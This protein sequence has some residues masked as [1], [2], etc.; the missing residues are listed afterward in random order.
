MTVGEILRL[1]YS[2]HGKVV[3]TSHRDAARIWERA[4]RRAGLPLAYSE[5]FTPRAR[6]SFGLAL[7]TGAAS[8]AEYLDIVF[9]GSAGDVG[10][11]APRLGA[12]LP[13][14]FGVD[15]VARLDPGEPS[16]QEAV[17]SCS[18]EI[19]LDGS[20]DRHALAG[21]CAEVLAAP[22]LP[23]ERERKGRTSTDDLRPAVLTLAPSEAMAPAGA[24]VAPAAI[25]VELATQPRGV[26]PGEL[27]TVLRQAGPLSVRPAFR[28]CRRTHQW[29]TRDGVRREPLAAALP[30]APRAQGRAS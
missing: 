10:G 18:W 6:L 4:L 8:D 21:L 27:E 24:T 13:E 16:L 9:E 23:V 29:I 3:W 26:R 17:T 12:M 28:R 7:P 1:R 19:E 25:S 5:G 14:G 22:A 30:G 2:K 20:W 11:L 15:G